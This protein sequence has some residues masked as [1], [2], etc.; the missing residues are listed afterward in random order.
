MN[1]LPNDLGRDA[2]SAAPN[3]IRLT[4]RAIVLAI[5]VLNS[6]SRRISTALYRHGFASCGTGAV[7]EWPINITPQFVSVGDQ[8]HIGHHARIQGVTAYRGVAFCPVIVLE[9]HVSIQQNLHLTCARKVTIKSHTAIAAN[10][11]VTDINHG[12]EDPALAPELQPIET[13]EVL[14]GPNCK[15]YNNVVILPGTVLGPHTIVAANSVVSGRTYPG[16]CVLAGAPAVVRKRYSEE[17]GRWVKTSEDG[18][19]LP[20]GGV[21][22]ENP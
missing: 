12:Y 9:D 2:Q 14:I 3:R 4:S 1:Q 18:A 20:G 6:L 8:V 22:C 17:L 16:F 11:T 19:F 10:V 13:A 15:L 5:R 7:V 21:I